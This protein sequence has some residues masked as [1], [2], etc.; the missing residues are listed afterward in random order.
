[1]R[2]F[3]LVLC[4][5]SFFFHLSAQTV[6]IT[7]ANRGIGLE[8]ASQYND[9]GYDVIATARSPERAK[10]LETLG[11][12]IEQLDVAN[13]NSV[14]DLA[15]KLEGA[16]IDILIN[17]AGVLHGRGDKLEDVDFEE[18]ERSF[19]INTIGPLRVTQALLPNLR[20]GKEKKIINITSR[21]GSIQHNSGGM[22]AYR[23]SKAALNQLNKTLS[24]ELGAEGFVCI[25]IHPGWVQTDMGG[26]QATYTTK[27][28]V[29]GMIDVIKQSGRSSNGKFYDLHG[30]E[31]PW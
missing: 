12:R 22:Y 31:L 21:L 26:S 24:H 27:R 17:N 7:G 8:F 2:F 18:V 19:D 16:P 5:L 4:S 25:V 23:A 9:L 6:L 13:P 20:K 28:S 29:A 11:V 1:M 10:K 15:K 3:I 14:A 30:N